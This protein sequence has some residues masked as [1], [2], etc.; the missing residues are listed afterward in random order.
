VLR[1]PVRFNADIAFLKH[2]VVKEGS[3]VEFRAEIFNLF[4][5]TQ[6][7]IYDSTLGNQANNTVNCYGG[8][9]VGYSAAGGDGT[10]CLTGSAFLHPVSAHRP[11]TGQLGIKWIF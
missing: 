9:G 6:F 2:W 11:R 7:R 10:D 1:N 3:S 5:N 4:N 8:L